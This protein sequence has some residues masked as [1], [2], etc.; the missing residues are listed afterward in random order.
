M[1]K[2]KLYNQLHAK[3]SKFADQ[4]EDN[5]FFLFYLPD[6]LSLLFGV[7]SNPEE[8]KQNQDLKFP[9]DVPYLAWSKWIKG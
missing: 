3:R 6:R 2:T 8:T 1:E 7:L 9:L 4:Q 5:F